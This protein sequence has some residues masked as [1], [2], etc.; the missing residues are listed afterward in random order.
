[1][2]TRGSMFCLLASAIIA[3]TAMGSQPPSVQDGDA[4][5]SETLPVLR[6]E[7]LAVQDDQER[8]D[9]VRKIAGLGDKDARTFLWDY[10]HNLPLP[11][12]TTN[13]YSDSFRVKVF[14]VILPIFGGV[15]RDMFLAAVIRR[16]AEGLREAESRLA[17][18]MYPG[19]LWGKAVRVL[20]RDGASAGV[21]Q[22]LAGMEDDRRLPEPFRVA[23]KTSLILKDVGKDES[24]IAKKIRDILDELPVRPMASIIPYDIYSDKEK[25]IAYGNSVSFEERSSE[26]IRWRD[27]GKRV[28]YETSERVLLSY[29]IASV[30]E[31][32]ATLRRDDV[33]RERRDCLAMLAA[34]LLSTMSVNMKWKGEQA[35][36]QYRLLAASLAEYVAQMDDPGVFSYR[37]YAEKGLFTF[38]NNTGMEKFRF[39][40]G[41][42]ALLDTP[43]VSESPSSAGHGQSLPKATAGKSSREP[44]VNVGKEHAVGG[45][46]IGGGRNVFMQWVFI[47]LGIVFLLAGTRLLRGRLKRGG[48][49]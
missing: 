9:I 37:F 47:C 39:K 14:D 16:E 41:F 45:R 23:V 25:R 33:P 31:I 48:K 6:S 26:F 43:V 30:R 2:T 44:T 42:Q 15:E 40:S 49:G 12:P 10:F 13:P 20:E 29:E 36:E 32:V 21:W 34:S 22:E 19:A 27:S 28:E 18:N 38:C 5:V 3:L 24:G 7:L 46:R 17:G 1:M 4:G 8:L 35:G 11:Q